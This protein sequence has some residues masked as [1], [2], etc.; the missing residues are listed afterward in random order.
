[1][2]RSNEKE[3]GPGEC[4]SAIG[5]KLIMI[6]LQ[7]FNTLVRQGHIKGVPGRKNVYKIVDVVQGYITYLK[8]ENRR[9]TKSASASRVQD[10][11]AAEI[12]LKIAKE[13]RDL[14][15]KDEVCDFLTETV[16]T[17]RSRLS[18]VPAAATRDPEVRVAIEKELDDAIADLNR[19]FSAAESN[20]R[21]G[22]PLVM[23]TEEADA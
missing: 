3:L 16:G 14:I 2:A 13:Q 11:R 17:F 7:W 4:N 6:E 22:R 21:S 18:G 20:A 10:A 9:S 5:S 15:P 12:E 8:D 1:M 23:E 19:S